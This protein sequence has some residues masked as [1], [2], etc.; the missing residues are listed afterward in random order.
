MLLI[1][2]L[3]HGTNVRSLA[4]EAFICQDFIMT[5]NIGFFVITEAWLSAGDCVPSVEARPPGF[6]FLHRPDL[7]SR[8]GGV[9]VIHTDLFSRLSAS[10]GC[11]STF[12][13]LSFILKASGHVLSVFI[14]R[15]PNST[16]DLIQEF[17]DF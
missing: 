8:A 7:T 9:A 6:S 1:S 11:L 13:I 17:T 2:G 10:F 16:S 4:S 15:P 14:Y 5:E 3:L 12:E